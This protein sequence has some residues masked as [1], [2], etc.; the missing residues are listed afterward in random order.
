MFTKTHTTVSSCRPTMYG[1]SSGCVVL[2]KEFY[3]SINTK[4]QVYLRRCQKKK[5]QSHRICDQV[6][7]WCFFSPLSKVTTVSYTLNGF[8]LYWTILCKL[9]LWSAQRRGRNHLEHRQGCSG[10]IR[11]VET[12]GRLLKSHRLGTFWSV[13]TCVLAEE[14]WDA[15][16]DLVWIS[17]TEPAWTAVWPTQRAPTGRRSPVCYVWVAGDY[18]KI[19]VLF[20]PPWFLGNL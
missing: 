4:T 2:N 3:S 7:Q 8:G 13:Q 9:V 18:S 16:K 20:W 11:T 14:R 1:G 15:D 12:I 5:N 17:L 6:G 10:I 19:R